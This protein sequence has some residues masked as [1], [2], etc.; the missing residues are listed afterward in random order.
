MLFKKIFAIALV[1]LTTLSVSAQKELTNELIWYSSTFS[2]GWVGG[3]NSMND[4]LHYTSLDRGED[5]ASVNKYDYKTGELV[6]T[7]VAPKDLIPVGSENSISIDAYELSSDEK[8]MVIAT[9]QEGIYRHSSKAFYWI[10]DLGSKEITMLSDTSKGK[11][12]LAEISPDGKKVAFVRENNLFYTILDEGREIQITFDGKMNEIIN[13]GTDWV[14]EEEF[15]FDKGFQWS[16]N[17]TKIAFYRTDETAVK[18]FQMAMYEGSLYPD[19]YTFKYPKAGEA[20]SKIQ[21]MV[22]T[23]MDNSMVECEV[24]TE[25]EYYVPRIQWTQSDEVLCVQKMNRHQNHLE[26]IT[27]RFPENRPQKDGIVP[28][29]IYDEVSETYI[30][31]NDEIHFLKDG[32][33]VMLSD[34]D[35]YSHVYLNSKDGKSEKQLTSGDFDVTNIKGV[36]EKNGLVYYMSG[37]E[38]P[39]Q[40]DLYVVNLKGSGKKDLTAK[41]GP[42][43]NDANFS[44]G[45]KYFINYW[46]SANEPYKITLHDAKGKKIK[47][48]E[49]NE[50][51]A[52]TIK[53]YTT[54]EKEFFTFN[55]ADDVE[56]NGWMIKPPEFRTREK[57]PVFLTIYGGPGHNTVTDAWGG[58]TMLWHH[59]LAQKGY[60]VVSVDPRGTMYRGSEHLKSTYQQMGKLETVDMIETAKYLSGLPFVDASRIGVQGWSYGGFLTSLCMTKG[61]DHFKMGIAVAPVTNWRYY[62]T[63]YTER[64]MRTPQ[65]NPEGYDDNSPINHVEKLNGP[66]L[67]VHGSADDNVHYQNTMEMVNA[68]VRANKQFDLFIY[69]DKNHGIYGGTTRLHLFNKMTDFIENN[70]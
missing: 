63:I 10:Y 64:F 48:L 2:M 20:N 41:I 53:E 45:F 4:G 3:L 30:D 18:Q 58:R 47:D 16:P 14:Y 1:G 7:L 13:G 37:E 67:L 9:E 69:P 42:G 26:F 23:L 33:F 68:L 61:A 19:Q 40:L 39:T 12:R 50:E 51:Y 11:Q 28:V 8:Q 66:Y 65:E 70:L 43:R 5:G 55:T 35:G 56:L 57:Y 29:E 34:K 31:L 27:F 24:G 60:L 52:N 46:S 21:I 15:G 22:F 25:D 59:M 54:L 62:D 38:G 44:K 49:T 17:G 36:D 6:A 32:R